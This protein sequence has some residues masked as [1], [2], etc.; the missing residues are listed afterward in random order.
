M[1]PRRF[2]A[3]TVA[4]VLL[5]VV[6]WNLNGAWD[7][8][9]AAIDARN[10]ARSELADL[11]EHLATQRNRR[12]EARLDA[13]RAKAERDGASVSVQLRNEQLTVMKAGRDDA[14]NTRNAKTAEVLVVKQCIGGANAALDALRRGAPLAIVAVDAGS[15]A[16][17][18]EVERAAAEGRVIGWKTTNELGKLLGEPTV[19]ICAVCHDGIAA[20][21]KTLRAAADAGAAATREGAGCSR[22][23]EAR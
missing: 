17:R 10:R 15:V 14:T 22:C 3:M 20:E 2:A 23:P 13:A 21:L 4:V 12:H 19:A 16:L 1:T 7:A 6:A 18:T 5:G 9:R 8:R 11:R